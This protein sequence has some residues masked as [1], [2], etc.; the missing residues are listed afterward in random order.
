MDVHA[1]ARFGLHKVSGAG[2]DLE[3]HVAGVEA[4][5]SV[6]ICVEV[7]HGPVVLFHGV[8]GSFGLF[9]S[10]FLEGDEDAGV[11]LAVEYEGDIEVLDVGDTF[12]V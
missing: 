11:N 2:R 3:D 8:C 9:G 10:Y 12:W 5:D 6:G 4:N 7:V 1:A